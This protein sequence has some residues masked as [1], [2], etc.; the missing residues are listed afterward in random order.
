MLNNL[1]EIPQGLEGCLLQFFSDEKAW[2]EYDL[3]QALNRA[4]YEFFQLELDELAI[5]QKHFLLFHFLYQ[6][7]ET[8]WQ[9]KIGYLEIHT[10]Q[11]QLHPISQNTTP[12]TDDP[13]K[14][15]YLD[16][17]QLETTQ[18]EDVL[19]LL[20]SFWQKYKNFLPEDVINADKSILQIDG[21]LNQQSLKQQYRLLCQQHHPD[22]GGENET[23]HQIQQAYQRLS[24]HLQLKA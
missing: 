4:G 1:R 21:E 7:Q 8:W 16:A 3:M 13:L 23:F 9:Q 19:K 15:Y 20:D 24:Q 14:T 5:F 6:L 18:Q 11:I 22:K 10:L 2:K 17:S 12:A